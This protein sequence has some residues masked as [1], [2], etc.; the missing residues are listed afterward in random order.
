MVP[1]I[2]KLISEYGGIV[3]EVRVPI[4]EN[5]LEVRVFHSAGLANLLQI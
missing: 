3:L 2:P 1:S 4:G 5:G